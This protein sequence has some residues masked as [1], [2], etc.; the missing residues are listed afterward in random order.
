MLLFSPTLAILSPSRG[1][2]S[3]ADRR[4]DM[5]DRQN[6]SPQLC[7]LEHP[8]FSRVGEP[9]FRRAESDNAP[10]MIVQLG[11]RE[12]ALPLRSLQREFAIPDD[13]ADGRMLAM[14]A[15]SLDFVAGLRP[16]DP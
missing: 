12:A 14:I 8:V 3:E 6:R 9:M 5:G 16:G 2:L 15:A 10:V 11:D 13:S 4:R 7:H 1:L